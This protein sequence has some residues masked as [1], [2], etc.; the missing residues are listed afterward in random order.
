M[1]FILKPTENLKDMREDW[2][3]WLEDEE[4][5]KVIGYGELRVRI[6]EGWKGV[7]AKGSKW[8]KRRIWKVITT[9]NIESQ[10]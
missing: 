3:L 5:C 4:V 9:N 8:I 1:K 7:C 6:G 2:V 10:I